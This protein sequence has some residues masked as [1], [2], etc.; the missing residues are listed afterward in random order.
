MTKESN[1]YHEPR[2]I[3][4][5]SQLALSPDNTL[6]SFCKHP[7]RVQEMEKNWQKVCTNLNCFY[8]RTPQGYIKKERRGIWGD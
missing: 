5:G 2:P 3:P 6:C 7:L 4:D 1:N 8:F